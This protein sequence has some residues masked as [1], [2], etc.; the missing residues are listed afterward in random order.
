MLWLLK[1]LNVNDFKNTTHSQ[2]KIRTLS[3]ISE[4][5]DEAIS[6]EAFVS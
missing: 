6:F 4:T 3:V 2:L 1:K 5:I